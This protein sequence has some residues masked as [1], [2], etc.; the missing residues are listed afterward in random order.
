MPPARALHE[1]RKLKKWR[2][3]GF[4]PAS[5]LSYQSARIYC[6]KGDWQTITPPAGADV[7]VKKEKKKWRAVGSN[8]RAFA[9]AGAPAYILKEKGRLRRRLPGQMY[10]NEKEKEKWRAVGFEPTGICSCRSTRVFCLLQF[11]FVLY[12]ITS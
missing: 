1:W 11:M 10:L 8:R 5:A 12:H 2:V 6:F 4:E 7:W 3:A 9:P